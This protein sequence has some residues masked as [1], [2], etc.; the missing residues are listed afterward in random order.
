[1]EL[2]FQF[3]I[4]AVVGSFLGG[5]TMLTALQFTD[6]PIGHMLNTIGVNFL[7]QFGFYSD[8]TLLVFKIIVNIWVCYSLAHAGGSVIYFPIALIII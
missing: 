4:L 3:N 1:M 7:I 6:Q 5:W 8:S 2:F